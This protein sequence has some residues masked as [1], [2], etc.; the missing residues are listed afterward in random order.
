MTQ[1]PRA[2]RGGRGSVGGGGGGS[3]QEGEESETSTNPVTALTFG[4]VYL[5]T[6]SGLPSRGSVL[7][8]LADVKVPHR[9]TAA[10][11]ASP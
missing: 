6:I 2:C 8:A 11:A 4:L 9:R 7:S 1:L 5:T 10:R 3:G